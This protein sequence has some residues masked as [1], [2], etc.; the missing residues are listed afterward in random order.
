MANDSR[1]QQGGD[2]RNPDQGRAHR[3]VQ[4]LGKESSEG[5]D[6]CLQQVPSFQGLPA[7]V[8]VVL[9]PAR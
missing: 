3:L 5:P 7:D 2:G 4:A 1:P 6:L 8:G 9:P